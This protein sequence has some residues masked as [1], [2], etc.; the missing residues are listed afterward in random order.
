[1]TA[2]SAQPE[3]RADSVARRGAVRMQKRS[4]YLPADVADRLAAMVDDIHFATRRPKHEVLTAALAV[5]IEHQADIVTKLG[6][7]STR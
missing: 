5:A 6:A 7:G 3:P 1:M 2:L 4:W